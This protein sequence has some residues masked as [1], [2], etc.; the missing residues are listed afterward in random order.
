MF[1]IGDRVVGVGRC[2]GL[3]LTG[4]VGV[5]KVFHGPDEHFGVEFKERKKDFHT[6]SGSCSEGYGWWCPEKNLRPME[7]VNV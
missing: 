5:I 4:L 3:D 1:K 7:I 6:L 2:D